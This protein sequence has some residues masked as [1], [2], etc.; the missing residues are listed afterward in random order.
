MGSTAPGGQ[1]FEADPD[2]IQS[3]LDRLCYILQRLEPIVISNNYIRNRFL[4]TILGR[5]IRYANPAFR[6]KAL[7]RS[8]CS[9]NQDH[10]RL[11]ISFSLYGFTFTPTGVESYPARINIH[12]A[13]MLSKR[14]ETSTQ[15]QY[16][17]AGIDCPKNLEDLATRRTRD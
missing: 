8:G 16:T 10:R 3:L 1:F 7:I 11:R 15:D 2:E 9:F 12:V 14:L 13:S 5:I 6:V 17:I 4:Y